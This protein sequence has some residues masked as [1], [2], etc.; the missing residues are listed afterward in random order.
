M[1]SIGIIDVNVGNIGSVENI[2]DRFS[3]DV[4]IISSDWESLYNKDLIIFPGV[5][6]FDSVSAA[7]E[8]TGLRESLLHILESGKYFL[9]ICVGFQY[10][11]DG[12]TEG[13]KKGLGFVSG[14]LTKFDSKLVKVPHMGWNT[15]VNNNFA[16]P[17]V[18]G[19]FYFTHSYRYTGL[20]KINSRLETVYDQVFLS[21][22]SVG[23]VI[24]V[25]FHP[26][27]SGK[28]GLLFFKTLIEKINEEKS[29]TDAS[30]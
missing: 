2:C 21:A 7:V 3:G 28:N 22:I 8:R 4:E 9:G 1:I 20:D 26:E 5:G 16:L 11:F 14:E 10:L 24:G 25:Q 18:D 30:N 12:S 15:V 27:K 29:H 19:D 23:N 13:C 6:H 17:H